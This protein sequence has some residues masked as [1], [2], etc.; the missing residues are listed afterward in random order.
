MYWPCPDRWPGHWK[1]KTTSSEDSRK[2]PVISCSP[3]GRLLVAVSVIGWRRGGLN[4]VLA[5]IFDLIHRLV[6]GGHQFFGR[7]RYV[8][9]RRHTHGRR[10]V[11]VEAVVGQERVGG[12]ALA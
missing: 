8:G 6:G 4:T 11:H 3:G 7:G 1:T 9:Q 10:Q 2:T 5:G 12:D